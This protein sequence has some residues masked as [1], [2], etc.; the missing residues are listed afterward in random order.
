MWALP[1]L[2]N[3]GNISSVTFVVWQTSNLLNLFLFLGFLLVLT[4]NINIHKKILAGKL[5]LDSTIMKYSFSLLIM[6]FMTTIILKNPFLELSSNFPWIFQ[7][8]Y[9]KILIILT[10]WF[11]PCVRITFCIRKVLVCVAE[12]IFEFVR[13]DNG[14]VA[15]RL[16]TMRQTTRRAR[17][18]PNGSLRV[19]LDS[20]IEKTWLRFQAIMKYKENSKKFL[21]RKLV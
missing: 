4:K 1:V 21:V 15:G 7:K 19:S 13:V 16:G 9:P 10:F 3:I 12:V 11:F 20:W 6:S 18:L 14:C 5:T 8:N 2:A 17:H